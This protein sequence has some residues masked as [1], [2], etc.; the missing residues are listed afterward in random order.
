MK[1]VALI[2]DPKVDISSLEDYL[3]LEK[4]ENISINKIKRVIFFDSPKDI[5]FKGVKFEEFTKGVF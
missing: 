5:V 1:K 4:C 2:I 3:Y